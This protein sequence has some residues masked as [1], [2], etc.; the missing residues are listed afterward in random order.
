MM[1]A[2]M[3][4]RRQ[5]LGW[6]AATATATAALGCTG[7]RPAAPVVRPQ[8]PPPGPRP[9]AVPDAW[10]EE[11]TVADLQKLMG[12]GEQSAR[13]ITEAYLRRIDAI[14]R[15]GP[16]L[17]AVI[18]VNPDA[19]GLANALD[20]ERKAGKLRGP[21]HGIPI[22]IKDNI[23][24]ADKMATTAGSLALVGARPAKD[25]GLVTRLRQAGAVLLGKANLSEW[26]NF[27]STRSVSGWSARGGQCRNPYELDRSPC[28]SSSGSAAAVAANLCAVA[29]GSETDG[30]I[31]CPSSTCG[32]VG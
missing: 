5:F 19:V 4:D 30:S 12:S 3:I 7:S 22:L 18:E 26:A 14:D 2:A 9:E 28:G 20:A 8:P 31:V 23:D 16:E 6:T 11:L 29:I 17:R 1:C 25:A 32:I 27:R 10:L 13:S 24:T 21:L 15:R